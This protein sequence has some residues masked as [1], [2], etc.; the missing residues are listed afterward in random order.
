MPESVTAACTP[1]FHVTH[2]S[3]LFVLPAT[4][5]TH[6]CRVLLDTLGGTTGT[7]PAQDITNGRGVHTP[8]LRFKPEL[9][10]RWI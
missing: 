1:V 8:D 7:V 10:L 2:K 6:D 4:V 5:N 3:S 9:S